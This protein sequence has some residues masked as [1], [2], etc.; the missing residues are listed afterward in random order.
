MKNKLINFVYDH[1]KSMATIERTPGIVE[2]YIFRKV[3]HRA[4]IHGAFDTWFSVDIAVIIPGS[5]IHKLCTE[6]FYNALLR[7]QTGLPWEQNS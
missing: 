5:T 4:L 3:K 1:K 2:K 6:A 7:K